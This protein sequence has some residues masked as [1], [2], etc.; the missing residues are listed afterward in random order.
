MQQGYGSKKTDLY[1]TVQLI[2]ETTLGINEYSE[3][4]F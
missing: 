4:I 3:K 2:R 1:I